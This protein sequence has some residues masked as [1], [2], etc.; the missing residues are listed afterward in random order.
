MKSPALAPSEYD[1]RY[2]TELNTLISE[3]D[4]NMMKLNAVNYLSSRTDS[5]G[6][7]DQTGAVVIQSPDG[8]FYKLTVANGGAVSGVA[9][10][11]G[12]SSNPYA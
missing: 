3:L 11:T 5:S 2:Q 6:D 8:T 1:Q 12:Q 7:I 9:I 10:T 4:D